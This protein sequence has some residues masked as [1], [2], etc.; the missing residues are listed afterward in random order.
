MLNQVAR[1]DFQLGAGHLIGT[2]L[3]A[4]LPFEFPQYYIGIVGG[5]IA[6]NLIQHRPHQHLKYTLAVR[7][8]KLQEA[9]AEI[10]WQD[11]ILQFPKR[12]GHKLIRRGRSSY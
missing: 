10:L 6:P 12:M 4:A 5:L 2:S 7:S 8:L 11:S 9:F 1:F 3:I